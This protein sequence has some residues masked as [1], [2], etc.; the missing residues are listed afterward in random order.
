MS[1]TMF[2]KY[3]GEL[4][5]SSVQ[6]DNGRWIYRK[7]PRFP[8]DMSIVK[9]WRLFPQSKRNFYFPRFENTDEF[10]GP[11]AKTT[12]ATRLQYRLLRAGRIPDSKFEVPSQ[13]IAV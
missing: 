2:P 1:L 6:R 7:G 5:N 13:C 11:V 9:R 4:R 3:F 12:I 8:N 10:V